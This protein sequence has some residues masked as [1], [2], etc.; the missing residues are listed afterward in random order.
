MVV[1]LVYAFFDTFG[2]IH[3]RPRADRPMPPKI[4]VYKVFNDGFIG[5]DYGSSA[6]QSVVLMVHRDRLTVIQ[7]RYI[8]RVNY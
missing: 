5:Q 3:A 4:L 8:E 6:A 2:I 1:N 7:F